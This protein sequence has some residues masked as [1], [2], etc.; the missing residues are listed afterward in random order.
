MSWQVLTCNRCNW[1]VQALSWL[2]R[3]V[4]LVLTDASTSATS[5]TCAVDMRLARGWLHVDV[6]C[7]RHGHVV[8]GESC[9][10]VATVDVTQ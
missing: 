9:R 4:L 7:A 3:Q 6:G 1:L 8:T 10:A 5:A 2:E